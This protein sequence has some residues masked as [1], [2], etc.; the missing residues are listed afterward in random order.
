MIGENKETPPTDFESIAVSDLRDVGGVVAA[1]ISIMRPHAKRYGY[2]ITTDEA[3]AYLSACG[4][5]LSFV[6]GLDTFYEHHDGSTKPTHSVAT[7]KQLQP[8]VE[9]DPQMFICLLLSN[10]DRPVCGFGLNL[11]LSDN[12]VGNGCVK[13]DGG[14]RAIMYV[15]SKP[16]LDNLRRQYK[17]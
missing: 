2:T 17:I 16:N 11:P 3:D 14:R 7:L 6:V 8:I 12:Q 13:M 9:N 1:V 5:A 10:S 4:L 15:L